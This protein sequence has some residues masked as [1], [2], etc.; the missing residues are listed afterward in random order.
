MKTAVKTIPGTVSLFFTVLFS[1]AVT[2]KVFHFK[3]FSSQLEMAP[4]LEGWG[5][6]TALII[7]AG[8]ILIIVLL[9]FRSK[10]L[11]GLWLTLGML[12]FFTGYIG[13]LLHY[14]K[15][16][17]CTCIGFFE[18]VICKGNLILN[19]G[20]MITAIGGMITEQ[21]TVDKN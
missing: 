6:T 11:P 2:V 5:K 8:Q 3:S 16:L 21:K 17:P 20:L 4:G 15:N 10:P 13:Y 14:G 18:K 1:Y 9:C 19:M 7:I 12:T